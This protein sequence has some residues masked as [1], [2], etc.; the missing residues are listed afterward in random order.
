MLRWASDT[1]CFIRQPG[2]CIRQ[3]SYVWHQVIFAFG[4]QVISSAYIR[5]VEGISLGGLVIAFMNFSSQAVLL[6]ADGLFCV[7][8]TEPIAFGGQ[9][10]ALGGQAILAFSGQGIC[11]LQTG[12]SVPR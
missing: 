10:V 7:R 1:G 12:Y 5:Q 2:Y 3:S 9:V 8:Q 11:V 6:S 4:R